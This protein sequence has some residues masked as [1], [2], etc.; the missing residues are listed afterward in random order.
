M[1]ELSHNDVKRIAIELKNAFI[2]E[3]HNDKN[4]FY[5]GPKEHYDAHKRLDALLDNVGTAQKAVWSAII[6]LI[7]VGLFVIAAVAAIKAG[8]GWPQ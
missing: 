2:T 7:T 6:G 4:E 8:T 3:V 5:I 1:S